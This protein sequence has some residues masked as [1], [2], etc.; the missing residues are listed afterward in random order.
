MKKSILALL[1]G[2]F[3]FACNSSEN[4]KSYGIAITPD[5]AIPSTQLIAEMGNAPEMETKIS[6]KIIEVCQ[7]MGCWFTLDLGNGETLRVTFHDEDFRIPKNSSG[8]TVVV[9]GQAHYRETSIEELKHIA[10]DAKKSKEE[11]DAIT[12]P[13]S[14]L[15]FE[16]KGILFTEN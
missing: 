3:L 9:Q 1:T 12:E 14:E 10:E 6:G 2:L 13:E 16:A 15:I 7:E 4:K 5:A 11:I 8:K